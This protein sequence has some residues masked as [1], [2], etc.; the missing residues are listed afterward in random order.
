M[1]LRSQFKALF[2]PRQTWLS[3]EA[4]L[5]QAGG[6]LG[7]N[8]VLVPRADCFY[9]R[10]SFPGMAA[11]QRSAALALAAKRAAP[12]PGAIH[13]VRW[14]GDVAHLWLLPASAS[15]HWD[16][17]ARLVPESAMLATPAEPDC[18]RLLQVQRGFE[19]QIWRDGVLAASRWWPEMPTPDAWR[20]FLRAGSVAVSD[21]IPL[22]SPQTLPLQPQP[23]GQSGTALAWTPAQLEQAFWKVIV[24]LVTFVLGWQLLAMAVWSVSRAWQES[25]LSDVRNASAPLIAARERAESARNRLED[26]IALTA[27]PVDYVL[28]ADARRLLPPDARVRTWFRDA[29]R[30][31]LEVASPVGDPRVFVQAFREH[32]VLSNVVANP[33]DGGVMQ[34]DIDL[35]Q[36]QGQIQNAEAVVP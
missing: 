17:Q 22:P 13:A 12:E 6:W 25:A 21:P 3:A 29:G 33:L 30:L 28:M 9:R 11:A 14:Q 27:T 32:P 34:L 26:F 2:S 7:P 35:E 4:T 24:A 18:E 36:S 10:L 31:R 16:D 23:W 1:T 20:Q 15:A 19:G 5:V 8:E